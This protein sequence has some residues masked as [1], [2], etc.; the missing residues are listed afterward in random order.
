MECMT[1]TINHM[2]NFTFQ[3][4]TITKS[5]STP[6]TLCK[7]EIVG[8]INNNNDYYFERANMDEDFLVSGYYCEKYLYVG[9]HCIQYRTN[10]SD[11]KVIFYYLIGNN[12]Y[13]VEYDC[14]PFICDTILERLYYFGLGMAQA[15]NLGGAML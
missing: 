14:L 10:L 5:A 15:E 1:M 9:N 2:I 13:R 11:S 12:S 8:T 3:F 7:C 6:S 4:D